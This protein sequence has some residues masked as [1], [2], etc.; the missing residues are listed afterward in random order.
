M[1]DIWLGLLMLGMAAQV[2]AETGVASV[3][4]TAEGTAIAGT[5]SFQDVKAG[6]KVTA[7]LSGLT[8]GEHGFHIHQFGSCA[9]AGK[10]SGGHFNPMDSPHGFLPKD[11]LRKAHAGD[12]G[13][14]T[15]AADGTAVLELTLP[16]IS[17]SAG[18]FDVAGRAVIIHEKAD[19]FSQPLGNA[20]GRI[21]CGV[22]VIT[23][24]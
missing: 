6:L 15:A 4:G 24:K 3:K 14:I 13:N 9:D 1:N 23:A 5:V 16:R 19:D 21:G 2:C 12:M 8:P 20:G 18:K 22:I 11:G 10:A 7:K 17:L